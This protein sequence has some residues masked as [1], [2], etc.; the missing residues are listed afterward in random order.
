MK[1]LILEMLCDLLVSGRARIQIQVVQFLSLHILHHKRQQ[2]VLSCVPGHHYL[3]EGVELPASLGVMLLLKW[4]LF[5]LE[6]SVTWLTLKSGTWLGRTLEL[7]RS[8][9]LGRK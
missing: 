8:Q 2:D 9:E 4:R 5:S 3:C 6:S 1:K 7:L